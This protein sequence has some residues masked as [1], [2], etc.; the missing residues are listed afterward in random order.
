MRFTVLERV[1]RPR[2]TKKQA[3]FEADACLVSGEAPG[4]PGKQLQWMRIRSSDVKIMQRQS[5]MQTTHNNTQ[6]KQAITL[7]HQVTGPLL[8]NFNT[9]SPLGSQVDGFEKVLLSSGFNQVRGNALLS[10][11]L[12]DMF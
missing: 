7:R 11:L 10:L 6:H 3:A 2:L 4:A 5:H 9:A 12:I 1:E 8:Y